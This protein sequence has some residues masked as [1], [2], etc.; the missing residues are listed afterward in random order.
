MPPSKADLAKTII[1]FAN[2]AGG[3]LYIGIMDTPRKIIGIDD[4]KLMALEEKIS[5][6]IHDNCEPSILP[7]ISSLSIDN[8]YILK[9]EIY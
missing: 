1:S 7:V 4:D 5:S 2:D 3:E 6:M 9:V 8:K